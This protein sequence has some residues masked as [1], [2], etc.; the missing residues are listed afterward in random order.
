MKPFTY[1]S[2][3][4]EVHFGT[5]KIKELPAL[6]QAWPRALVIGTE[7]VAAQVQL[8]QDAST[9]LFWF[10]EVVQH[11][12]EALVAK[13]LAVCRAEEASVLVAIGGG[14][15]V[16]LAKALAR[17]LR[18]PIVAV[19]TTYAGSEMTD[20]WGITGANGKVTGKDLAV[21]PRV[22]LYD[23]D[24]TLGMRPTLA[25]SS[26]MNAMAHLME[27]VYAPAGNVLTMHLAAQGMGVLREGLEALASGGKLTP[28]VNE[29]LLL[30]AFMGGKVLGEVPMALHHKAA[31][32]L[33]GSFGLD[34]AGVHTVLQSYVLQF[35][36][37]YLDEVVRRMF[38]E[39]LG[40][41]SPWLVLQDLA[42]MNGLPTQLRSVGLAESQIAEAAAIMSKAPYPNPAPLT[43]EGLRLLLKAAY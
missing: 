4:V 31:H 23:P 3:Q 25:A 12:P 18:L 33:G 2:R 24:L 9:S 17:E 27:G 30:G 21:Q 1:Q 6:L 14:S 40:S 26:A 37:P 38:V 43:E 36:W 20:I 28:E 10:K 34:H 15:A 22:V 42:R 35:Q 7:R 41:E 29:K 11:V 8:L 5:G 39:S 32:T 19:P 13:A 16:G